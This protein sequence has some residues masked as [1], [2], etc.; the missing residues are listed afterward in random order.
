[1]LKRILW[2]IT[3]FLLIVFLLVL[4]RGPILRAVGSFLVV[5][6]ELKKADVI[7]VLAGDSN[8]RVKQGVALYKAGFSKYII[9]SGG[10]TTSEVSS[11][12]RMKKQALRLGVPEDAIIL[13]PKS[14]H[15]YD[16]PIFVKPILLKKGFKSAIVI[17]SPYHTRRTSFLF[18][19]NFRRSGIELIYYPVQDSY[20]KVDDWWKRDYTRRIVLQEYMKMVGSLFLAHR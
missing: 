16:H 2:C 20:F 10:S 6:D 8:E 7:V 4:A 13:E 14:L 5:Q 17:S 15:T 19:R 9:M 12:E 11:A 18:N 1:M 3:G